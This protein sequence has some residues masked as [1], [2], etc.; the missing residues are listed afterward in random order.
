MREIH[1]LPN[2]CGEFS[3]MLLRFFVSSRLF[4]CDKTSKR[5][6]SSYSEKRSP[7]LRNVGISFGG[8][9]FPRLTAVVSGELIAFYQVGYGIAAF[10]V[11]P[12]HDKAGIPLSAIYAGASLVA[13][14][15][16]VLAFLV[17][18]PLRAKP[19]PVSA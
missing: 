4:K 10:G 9:E 8:Q 19:A 14:A 12:L 5:C 18:K 3:K 6:I 13:G 16:I 15:L 11:G 2:I 17:A 7:K 1:V